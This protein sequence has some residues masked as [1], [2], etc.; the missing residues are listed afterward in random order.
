VKILFTSNRFDPDIGGIEVVSR[1]LA[2]AFV[3]CG[4]SVRLAT[5]SIALES[6]S[7]SDLS[8]AILRRPSVLQL[9]DVYKWA[10]V[11]F[12]NNLEVRRLWPAPFFRKPLVIGLQTWIRSVDGNRSAI[13][14][15]KLAALHSASAVVACSEAV[16]ADSCERAI[17][18]GNPYNRQLFRERPEISRQQS[19]VFLGRLVSDKGVDLLLHAYAALKRPDWPLT[20]I[21]SGP[22]Q[23]ALMSLADS[24]GVNASVRFVGPLQGDALALA[25]NSHELMVV[26]SRWREPFGVVVLEGQASGCVVLASDGGG[27]PDAVGSAGMLFRRGDHADL[28][29]KL[30]LLIEDGDLRKR[31]R[32]AAPDHLAHFHDDVVCAQYLEILERVYRNSLC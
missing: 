29:A 2:G 16:R 14:R 3:A 13:H 30:R 28:A 24:L 27:L 10:D 12:Q 26:P 1:I 9:A 17:V 4:H 6:A 15:L 22:E 5:H 20:I 23:Q 32:A 18:I 31:L 11:V 21:G 19:I 7:D 8:F 25:L